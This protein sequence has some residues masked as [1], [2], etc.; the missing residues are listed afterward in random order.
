MERIVRPKL[1]DIPNLSSYKETFDDYNVECEA[2]SREWRPSG[3]IY[4][5][6]KSEV[7]KISESHCSFCDGYPLNDT[8]K[9]TIEHYYPKA[10]YKHKTYEWDNLYFCC[11]RCQ[12][13]SNSHKPFQVTLKPDDVDYHFDNHFWFDAE[14]GFVKLNN[15]DDENARIFLERYGINKRPE[16]IIAR[17]NR[18]NELFKLYKDISHDN[19]ET[20]R[21]REGQRYIFDLYLK[22][23]SLL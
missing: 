14:D 22:V 20:E 1:E 12:S 2:G 11:D 23:R 21:L 3:T 10:E 17:R 8:S 5:L 18:Y 19:L 4:N 13:F 7:K 15:E 9:E 16:K 6:L